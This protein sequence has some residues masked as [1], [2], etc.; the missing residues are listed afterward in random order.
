MALHLYRRHNE[1][2]EGK[3][4]KDSHSGELEERAKKWTRCS[5]PI[6]AAGAMRKTFK[7]RK[8]GRIFW[9]DAKAVAARWEAAGRWPDDSD[10]SPAPVVTE[11]GPGRVT[12]ADAIKSWLAY[13]EKNSAYNTWLRYQGI[14][15][16]IQAYSDHKGYTIINQW[17]KADVLD[18]RET[19]TTTKRT[20]NNNMG[21]VKV[22]FGYCLDHEWIDASPAARVKAYKSRDATDTRGEQKL[23]FDDSE[24]RRMYAATGTYGKE[25][26]KQEYKYRITGRDLSDFISVSVYTGLR[27]SD[28]STFHVSRLNEI[29]E[30]VIR[31]KKN[32][33]L[34]S[35]WLPP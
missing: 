35:T 21:V 6:I 11:A 20:S 8:T 1:R 30:V 3:H 10:P 9:D 12:V 22:F 23:P 17:K 28:V 13:H 15:K 7:R 24:L 25:D 26:P 33:A 34:V 27:I 16:I 5:C 2:C 18:F 14:A 31:A 32:G 19:W 4:P 29:G